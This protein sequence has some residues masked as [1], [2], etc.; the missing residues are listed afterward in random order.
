MTKASHV[1]GACGIDAYDATRAKDKSS[2]SGRYIP[3]TEARV[4]AGVCG[5]RPR[6]LGR[7]ITLNPAAVTIIVKAD[8]NITELPVTNTAIENEVL[9]TVWAKYGIILTLSVIPN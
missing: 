2:G 6:G 7:M 4:V 5:G 9:L 1:V 8:N 3:S